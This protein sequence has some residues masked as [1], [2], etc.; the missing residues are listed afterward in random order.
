MT[1]VLDLYL[2]S[3][4]E[5]ED[6]LYDV[7]H[8]HSEYEC[9]GFNTLKIL[10]PFNLQM[11]ALISLPFPSNHIQVKYLFPHLQILNIIWLIY[12]V[13]FWMLTLKVNM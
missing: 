4:M 2:F 9:K 11:Y 8:Q 10:S 12:L 13:R 1:Q 3:V 6:T 5:E 7:L